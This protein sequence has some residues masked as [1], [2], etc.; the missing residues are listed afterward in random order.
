[1]ISATVAGLGPPGVIG[2]GD[3]GELGFPPVA[4]D[5]AVLDMTGLVR[6]GG[7]GRHLGGTL[8]PEALVL[9][10]R[11]D[12]D[13]ALGERPQDVS[14]N[15]GQLPQ[16][17]APDGPR[18]TE[19]GQL[20]P[21]R[22]LVHGG[23]RLLPQV[24]LAH[25]GGGPPP[26]GAADDVRDEDVGVQLRVA[27]PAGAMPEAGGHEPLG[28]HQF[29]PVLP[30][31]DVG[32][33]GR[34]V[35]DHSGDG[36]VMRRG[37]D[38]TYL[39]R[40]ERPQERHALRSGERQI[41]PGPTANPAHD[42]QVLSGTAPAVEQVAQDDGIHHSGQMESGRCGADPLSRGLA[43]AQV[44]VVDRVGHM[45]EVI[46]GPRGHAQATYR[47]HGG[48]HR[49]F[50]AQDDRSIGGHDPDHSHL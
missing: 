29:L 8:G 10:G 15:V 1:M 30:S 28:L 21:Q 6:S 35:V 45:V 38:V 46:V 3:V 34:Q 16:A 7:E 36:P 48:G 43:A 14:R 37:H 44:V 12:L 42:P 24:E 18:H 4:K 27:G 32:G 22:R 5:I 33:L 26:V 11:L 25:V 20:G 19:R 39:G 23:G 31:T 9:E 40:P 41:E 13:P 50:A 2:Q 49:C 47:E 17:V